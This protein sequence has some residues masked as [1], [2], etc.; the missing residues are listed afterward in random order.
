MYK[1]IAIC[2]ECEG[3]KFVSGLSQEDCIDELEEFKERAHITYETGAFY[4]SLERETQRM[5]AGPSAQ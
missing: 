2:D 4:N 5:Q 1:L 3:M